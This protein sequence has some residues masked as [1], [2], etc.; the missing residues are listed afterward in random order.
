MMH[1]LTAVIIFDVHYGVGFCA[2]RLHWTTEAFF[3]TVKIKHLQQSN[4]RK[5]CCFYFG[6]F[7]QNL[8]SFFFLKDKIYFVVY[9]PITIPI[10]LFGT[11]TVDLGEC[12]RYGI[13]ARLGSNINGSNNIC[14]LLAFDSIL[15]KN[16]FNSKGKNLSCVS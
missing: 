2:L 10:I 4:V 16:K 11:G 5:A 7:P 14:K 15:E 13:R 9:L 8:S 6:E 1:M 12:E 3:Q